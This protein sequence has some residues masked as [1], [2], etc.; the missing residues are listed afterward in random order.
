MKTRLTKQKTILEK[1]IKRFNK[2]FSA[3]ELLEEAKKEDKTIGIATVYRFLK[4]FNKKEE[5]HLYNCSRKRVYSIKSNNH[6]H[7]ICEKCGRITHFD[8]D[9]INFLKN[10]ISGEIC[11]FQVDVY[12]ICE[13]CKK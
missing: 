10:K 6:C 1:S 8:V 5:V 12:G 11:H 9:Q 2:F 3:D 7:F 4:D 13:K